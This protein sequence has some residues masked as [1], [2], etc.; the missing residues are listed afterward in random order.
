MKMAID[1]ELIIF[2]NFGHTTNSLILTTPPIHLF[3]RDIYYL[4]NIRTIQIHF[5]PIISGPYIHFWP[6]IYDGIT[7]HIILNSGLWTILGFFCSIIHNS[8]T[9]TYVT[10]LR[11]ITIHTWVSLW[12]I[13]ITFME[14]DC[15]GTLYLDDV[16]RILYFVGHI[17]SFNSYAIYLYDI[18]RILY[19]WDILFIWHL[20]NMISV[21]YSIYGIWCIWNVIFIQH[22]W[23]IMFYVL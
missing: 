11:I 22:S 6:M 3:T 17:I 18:Y 15:Y 9:G 14:Y 19:L 20:C 2:W 7:F 5:W 10:I 13:Y 16:Y 4:T 1:W 8:N 12:S 23:N 21:W